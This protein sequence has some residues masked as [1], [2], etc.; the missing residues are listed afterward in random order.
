MCV[1]VCVCGGDRQGVDGGVFVLCV[2][3]CRF[4]FDYAQNAAVSDADLKPFPPFCDW[5]LP[6]IVGPDVAAADA[7]KKVKG[8]TTL[9]RWVS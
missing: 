7:G 8:G 9:T 3:T 1:Y 6:R 2:G 4:R 5:L